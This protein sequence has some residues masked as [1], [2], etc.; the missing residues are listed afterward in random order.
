MNLIPR[1][2]L[3]GFAVSLS[4]TVQG[5]DKAETKTNPSEP[6]EMKVFRSPACGCCEKW[7]AHMKQEGFKIVDMP[8]DD[9]ESVKAK[10]GVP[11]HLQSCHTA[12]VAGHIVEGHVP[13]SDVKKM[14]KT[15]PKGH[16]I[17]APGMPVGSPGMEVGNLAGEYDVILFD[18]KGKTKTFNKYSK[19]Q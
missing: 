6:V 13:A 9:M 10:L 7:I 12:E 15:T 5:E 8:T 16:G 14:L 1:L 11:G 4:L 19:H 18:P 17:S 2:V 3:A